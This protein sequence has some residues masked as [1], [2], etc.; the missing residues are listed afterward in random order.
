MKPSAVQ[1]TTSDSR[2][3]SLGQAFLVAAVVS[4]SIGL[5]DLGTGVVSTPTRYPAFLSLLPALLATVLAVLGAYSVCWLLVTLPLQRLFKL[6][7]LPSAVVLGVFLTTLL[8]LA[9]LKQP[10]SYSRSFGCVLKMLVALFLC[11]CMSVGAYFT[12]RAL[13]AKPRAKRVL[14]TLL[15]A[16]PFLLAEGVAFVWLR[17]TY[18][19]SAAPIK[20]ILLCIACALAVVLTIYL[21][22]RTSSTRPAVTAIV[23]LLILIVASPG[24]ASL[25]PLKDVAAFLPDKGGARLPKHVILITV[26]TL[27]ADALSCYNPQALST[28]HFD[29]LA[30]DAVLFENAC[31][32]A[33]WTMPAVA[34]IMTGL[35]PS[36]HNAN[37]AR[38]VLNDSFVTL[39]EVVREAG[40]YT[41]AMGSNPHLRPHKNISQGFVEYDFYPKPFAERT[42]GDRLLARLLPSRF[43]PEVSTRRL[44]DLALDWLD[45]NHSRD[46]FL[47]IHY[48]DPHIPYSPPAEFLPK[49]KPP[50]NLRT[51]FNDMR[52]VRSGSLRLTRPE[53][54]W[55]RLLYDA[56]VRY[57]DENFG[58]LMAR[59]KALGIY[60]EALIIVSSDHGE[61]FWEHGNFEHGHTLYNEV[62][63]VPLVIKHPRAAYRQR[64]QTP[65]GNQS[66]MAT[67]LELCGVDYTG[68]ELFDQSL[69]TLWETNPE[70]S[71]VQP[72]FGGGA[73]YYE[74]KQSVAFDGLKY[75]HSVITECEELY[76]WTR[77]PAEQLSIAG[78]SPDKLQRAQDLLQEHNSVARQLSVRYGTAD[79]TE[80]E[81]DA[82]MERRLRSLG[83]ID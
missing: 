55:I 43:D 40:Y 70:A 51:S 66:I 67:I 17:T 36:V 22:A 3:T 27:R 10:I 18:L 33:P 5:V 7:A 50:G 23:V 34:S 47:W 26:D 60:D 21:F 30:G 59:L 79:G 38:S 71:S 29:E 64:I 39:A 25:V 74:E 1:A 48:F 83:Y 32:A 82:E 81:L 53:R 15:L 19:D 52:K 11:G 46:F 14:E 35:P 42:L 58:R 65:V 6:E 2:L 57:V 75:I 12:M 8:M 9:A 13:A 37:T 54:A 73:L 41:A 45:A 63:R 76:D 20:S 77:D 24:L 28:P 61:E 56:E 72:V 69:A 16:M 78:S 44:T 4:L 49:F 62:L 31:S 80:E 68:D